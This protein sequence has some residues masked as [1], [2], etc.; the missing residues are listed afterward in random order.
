ILQRPRLTITLTSPSP[1]IAG[2]EFD[3]T[4]IIGN[5]GSRD[6]TSAHLRLHLP[7]EI[8][9]V[10]TGPHTPSA[11]DHVDTA[12]RTVGWP[13]LG[14]LAIN[15]SASFTVRVRA[16]SDL[17]H[18]PITSAPDR[19]TSITV[20]GIGATVGASNAVS[21]M[22][23]RSV[24]IN[25]PEM[26]VSISGPTP[27]LVGDPFDY[28]LTYRNIG[29][30]IATGVQAQYTLPV[31]YTIVSTTPAATSISGQVVTWDI[32]DV[33]AGA[34]GTRTVRVVTTVNAADT[35]THV[36]QVSTTSVADA[37]HNNQASPLNVRVQFPNLGVS[38]IAPATGTRLPVGESHTVRANFDNYGDGLARTSIMTFTFPPEVTTFHGLPAGC[39]RIAP[40]NLVRCNV[41]DINP[42]AS[43]S[44]SFQFD[45]PAD[46]PPDD[47]AISVAIS[48]A[49]PER[50]AA[51]GNN[52][53]SRSL[54]AVR[55][56]VYVRAEPQRYTH[57]HTIE[58]GRFTYVHFLVTYGNQVAAPRPA[59]RTHT[60][61][62]VQL[63][64]TLPG[65]YEER[66]IAV[67][68]QPPPPS[69]YT[70]SGDR[71]TMTF[72]LGTLAPTGGDRQFLVEVL[73]R[74]DAPMQV[75]FEARIETSTP[76]DVGGDNNSNATMD[77]VPP[78]PP[79]PPA[80][81]SSGNLRM[82][83]YSTFD[84]TGVVHLT[85]NAAFVWPTGEVLHFSPRLS[86][87]GISQPQATNPASPYIHRARITGWSIVAMGPR[88]GP[89]I[90]ATGQDSRLQSGCR[91]GATAPPSGSLLNGCVYP[92]PGASPNLQL[93]NQVVP[94]L[95]AITPADIL[96]QGKVYWM[97]DLVAGAG[98]PPMHPSIYLFA[99]PQ[100]RPV[101]IQVEV[102]AEV[103]TEIGYQR[104]PSGD[105]TLN[106]IPLPG[107][108]N[109]QFSPPPPPFRQIYDTTFE[110]TLVV[111]RSVVGPGS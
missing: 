88:G 46:F 86:D 97:A 107:D 51:L 61:E 27:I 63:V 84:P 37:A 12:T 3:Y 74:A 66:L 64:I 67:G 103:H 93:L 53:D 17:N 41:G 101:Q 18:F 96:N 22:A 13:N 76:G 38:L 87:L 90:A 20:G 99:L 35:D 26:S 55:P 1:V 52:E 15:G 104:G 14:L 72:D 89:L 32:G 70:L 5:T 9:Y 39:A 106:P 10:P 11:P 36:G 91:G 95:D 2:Q 60:A 68:G 24:V 4:I 16:T 33:A 29:A 21:A 71:R 58:A 8:D 105:V 83:I 80:T 85:D 34:S 100:L 45:L 19:Q 94:A 102:E 82:S 111:P 73:L 6:A 50:P 47:V 109:D 7:L 23:A 54:F 28:I 49:T 79:V 77:V 31:G 44:R 110:I 56:N 108:P 98:Y 43:D 62:N 25:R 69:A 78:P 81:G 65:N 30:A 40:N 57:P 42:G 48:T 92:Y 75:D 59:N